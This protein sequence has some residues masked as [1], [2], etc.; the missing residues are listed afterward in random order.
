LDTGILLLD[1][2]L[3]VLEVLAGSGG[4]V[5]SRSISVT[6]ALRKGTLTYVIGGDEC[7]ISSPDF[8][9]SIAKTFKSLLWR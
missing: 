7:A 9:A 3:D 5:L 1:E 8:T 4:D 2:L 6:L